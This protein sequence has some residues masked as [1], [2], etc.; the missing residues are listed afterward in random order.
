MSHMRGNV[1]FETTGTDLNPELNPDL[2]HGATPGESHSDIIG[3][4][5][6][7]QYGVKIE[8]QSPRISL[9]QYDAAA[10]RSPISSERSS[11]GTDSGTE[12]S[13][14]A[15]FYHDSKLAP[16]PLRP[17]SASQHGQKYSIQDESRPPNST[18]N[19]TA[20]TPGLTRGHKTPTRHHLPPGVWERHKE[21]IHKLYIEQNKPLTELME[22]MRKKGI[23][24]TPRMYKAKFAQWGFVKNNKQKDVA[25]MLRLQRERGAVGKTTA[26]RRHG[27]EIDIE[28]YMKRK[29]I[30]NFDLA[31]PMTD[32]DL[33][34]YLRALTPPPAEPQ[35]M[36]LPSHL[37][38]Q[39][40]LVSC[41]RDLALGW[42]DS[43]PAPESFED[44]FNLYFDG[45]LCEATRDF[46]RAC[47]FF[48]RNHNS[49]GSLLSQRAFSS[50]HLILR[51]PSALGLFDLLVASV[52]SP[53]HGLIKELWK[54]LAGY[55]EVILGSS[56]TLYR[57][58]A[59]L[60]EVFNNNSLQIGVDFMFNC[61]E[62]IIGMLLE[63][64]DFAQTV[65][66][67]ITFFLLGDLILFN[68][69]RTNLPSLQR[70]V[71][72]TSRLSSKGKKPCSSIVRFIEP[73]GY[74]WQHGPYDD[75]SAQLAYSSL[76]LIDELP[77][78]DDWTHWVSWRVIA[79]F[80]RSRCD[81]G[82]STL[83][84]RHAL[85]RYAL[86]KAIDAT[87]AGRG[88]SDS[89]IFEN[90]ETLE[91]WHREAGDTAQELAVRQRREK[92]LHDYLQSLQQG[93]TATL[94]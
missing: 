58:F 47:W 41:F 36:T 28:A 63:T 59:A 27:R 14:I 49:H 37:H 55:A 38:A 23:E 15:A 93:S 72:C 54:Y 64:N 78:Q 77:N 69:S 67:S 44:D 65:V 34:D 17:L 60:N 81:A 66:P 25:T 94:P 1:H 46:S 13:R 21:E 12:Q 89:Q 29:G 24:A 75:H 84:P 2:P 74:L 31:A 91:A 22:I 50:L 76:N 11:S 9:L 18:A 10:G 42:H 86:E 35:H 62:S 92:G 52:M 70:A 68:S 43:T 30:S 4:Y 39:E 3:A 90:M 82:G 61:M 53:D 56:S 26:F 48:S 57:L 45:E 73:A 87:E 83:G 88:F 40:V 5:L 16:L 33:P 32:A 85:A 51:A 7:I 71:A 8:S 6:S 79:H 80:H 19:T 20:L